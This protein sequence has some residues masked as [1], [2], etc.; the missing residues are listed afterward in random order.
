MRWGN[1]SVTHWEGPW[2]QTGK[3]RLSHSHSEGW[4]GLPLGRGHTFLPRPIGLPSWSATQFS[5]H[6]GL[7]N[8]IDGKGGGSRERCLTWSEFQHVSS[9]WSN[10]CFFPN[11]LAL[12]FSTELTL[13]APESE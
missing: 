7:L 1:S 13:E 12:R 5:R 9:F 8:L 10:R 2:K 4:A 11:C 3:L 6:P